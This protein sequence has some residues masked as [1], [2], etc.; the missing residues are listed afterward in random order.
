MV[1]SSGRVQGA[2]VPPRGAGGRVEKG[3]TWQCAM[4]EGDGEENDDDDDDD[5]GGGRG[6]EERAGGRGG[7]EGTAPPGWRGR[8]REGVRRGELPAT[9]SPS[10]PRA[11][12]ADTCLRR[13]TRTVL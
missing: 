10:I 4:S 8:E 12:T 3:R 11:E 7:A 2:I 1:W 9:R 13:Y 6:E 5:E